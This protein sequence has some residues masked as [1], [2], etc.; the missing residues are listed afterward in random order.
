MEEHPSC[1]GLKNR[2]VAKNG[3]GGVEGGNGGEKKGSGRRCTHS[4]S[5]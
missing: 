4:L 1:L 3:H 2:L 5:K